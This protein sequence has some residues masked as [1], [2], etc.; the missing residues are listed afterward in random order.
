MLPTPLSAAE[1]LDATAAFQDRPQADVDLVLATLAMPGLSLDQSARL[2]IGERDAALV[3]L[4]AAM[5]GP[6]LD[7]ATTCPRCATRLDVSLTT[8]ALLIEPETA[9][10]PTV[11]FGRRRF[12]IRKLNG[13]DLAAA[14]GMPDFDAARMALA[15]RCLVP[16]GRATVPAWLTDDQL[17]AVASAL[18]AIDPGSD[19]YVSLTCFA[20]AAAWNAPV[21]IARILAAEIEAVAEA[22]MD[23]IHLLALSYHWSEAAILALA[24]ARRRAYLRRLRA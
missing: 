17:E 12:E 8:D 19:C 10:R 24:P 11:A 9:A 20:C 16:L 21:D 13:A 5:F 22:L 23:D 1:L 14:A 4:Y 2:P 18:A 7:L 15:L 3:R 6:R